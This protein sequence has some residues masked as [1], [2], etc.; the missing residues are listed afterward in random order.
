MGGHEGIDPEVRRADA[1]AV[2]G[3]RLEE[4][5]AR[6]GSRLGELQDPH[7][8]PEPRHAQHAVRLGIGDGERGRGSLPRRPR[9]P[10]APPASSG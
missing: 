7:D 5:H 6:E 4:P 1:A 10:A 9:C 8:V 2:A 3:E